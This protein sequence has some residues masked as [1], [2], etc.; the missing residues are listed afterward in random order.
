MVRVMIVLLLLGSGVLGWIAF[1]QQK[2]IERL[3]SAL[4]KGGDVEKLVQRIQMRAHQYT[5]YNSRK[6]DE[7]VQGTA[8]ES[9]IAVY[10]RKWAQDPNVLWGN[11]TINKASDS[12]V[13]VDGKRYSDTNYRIQTRDKNAWFDRN[14]IANFMY[15]LESKSRKVKVTELNITAAEK[16]DDHEVPQD[17]WDVDF[18][19]TVRERSAGR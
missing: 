11:L 10:V 8:N 5:Q 7:G 17:K 9:S 4:A 16:A 6:K 13:D 14:R 2:E 15:I 18:M 12:T 19:L 3:D 1:Q